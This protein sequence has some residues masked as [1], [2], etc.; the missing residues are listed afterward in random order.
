MLRTTY[1][2]RMKAPALL[3]AAVVALL[4]PGCACDDDLNTLKPSILVTPERIDMGQR[5]VG[6]RSEAGF[7]VGNEGT[8]PV[9]VLEY[10]VD[11]LPDDLVEELGGGF[12]DASGEAFSVVV[13]PPRVAAQRSE[14]GRLG[15]LPGAQGRYA[16]LLV[17]RSDDL[18]RPRLTVPI[19]GEGG[20]P[21]IE[22]QPPSV[23]F[24]V[25]NEGPGASRIVRL[26]N[27]GF[28][29]LV[30][31]D[32]LLE[33]PA[34]ALAF[35]LRN[36]QPRS[37]ELGPGE[38]LS[39]EV[40]LSPNQA[41]VLA[42]GGAT[43]QASLVALSNADN[44][45]RLEV[46][47]TAEANLAPQAIAVEL[48]SR[49]S[50]VKVG[51]GREVIIDG[52]DTEDPEGDPF[53]FQWTLAQRPPGDD[54]TI[55]LG[56]N[57]GGSCSDDSGCPTQTGYRCTNGTCRQVA[58][59]RVTPVAVGTYV[60]RLRAT[61]ARGAYKEA[62]ARILPRDLAV[63]L[64]WGS[65]P[66][67]TCFAPASAECSA[68]TAPPGVCT[69]GTEAQRLRCCQQLYCCGQNDLDL[70]LVRPGGTLGDYGVCPAECIVTDDT[71][72]G[73]ALSENRC[74]E[75]GDAYVD[76]CRQGGSDCAFE[77]RFPEWFLPGRE[78]DPRLDLDDVRGFGP[79]VI[80]LN[81]PANGVYTTVVHYCTDRIG[82]GALA[83][84]KVYVKGELAHTAGPQLIASE[85][86]AW[87]AGSLIRSGG[88]EEGTWQFVS[89]PNLFDQ[90]VG[91]DLCD[92]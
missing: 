80:T 24:G 50:E 51:L 39:V 48:I 36:E 23:S 79:E 9:T 58:W 4:A 71:G 33:Q 77:N 19:L 76:T 61:D 84:V 41:S 38:A 31:S 73:P 27:V 82:E 92:P 18:E 2:K 26:V 3:A 16:G 37:A 42:S 20:P 62:E 55:L 14:E 46:P 11:P 22:A 70:H 74:Y 83:T 40:V 56:N 65:T 44:Q 21:R 69:D 47:L 86:R 90:T 5:P 6:S 12:L 7:R 60:V 72:T 28:D 45:P 1:A 78:D 10:R 13:G 66:T 81:R 35:G 64:E 91:P 54:A 57:V 88:P 53:T 67:A 59:T 89:V 25:V 17:V 34:G 8:A 85:G 32:V 68:C 52:S 43:L 87:I 30:I 29:L 49:R 15:F 63:V 75:E